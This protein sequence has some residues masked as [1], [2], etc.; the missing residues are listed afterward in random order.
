[1]SRLRIRARAPSIVAELKIVFSSPPHFP[2]RA[3]EPA[4]SSTSLPLPVATVPPREDVSETALSRLG[5][6]AEAL[7]AEVRGH[8]PVSRRLADLGFVE[9]TRVRLLRRAPLGDPIVFELRGY[10]I[11]LRRSEADRILVRVIA[12]KSQEPIAQ[13]SVGATGATG[14]DAEQ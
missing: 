1:M 2:L 12:G 14:A 10:R 8:S 3:P 13:R 9:G 11:C 4:V 7:I 6:G 5:P